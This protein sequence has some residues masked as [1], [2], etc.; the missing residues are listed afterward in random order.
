[1]KY[2]LSY[3]KTVNL[4]GAL[5]EASELRKRIKSP[6]QLSL[7]LFKSE[8][9]VLA[10]YIEGSLEKC[11]PFMEAIQEE[12]AQLAAIIKPRVKNKVTKIIV[13]AIGRAEALE[14]LYNGKRAADID[15]KEEAPAKRDV[16]ACD[17]SSVSVHL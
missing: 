17:G 9:Y 11:R 1:M 5:I 3:I 13:S 4:E 6:S 8:A 7:G 14:V 10:E 15:T 2:I 12:R 16:D